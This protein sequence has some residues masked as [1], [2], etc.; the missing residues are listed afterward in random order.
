MA[1]KEKKKVERSECTGL[2]CP[3]ADGMRMGNSTLAINVVTGQTRDSGIGC[4]SCCIFGGW[5]GFYVAMWNNM[6]SLAG[7]WAYGGCACMIFNKVRV[8]IKRVWVTE[9]TLLTPWLFLKVRQGW[10]SIWREP[11]RSQSI[12]SFVPPVSIFYNLYK[13]KKYS[14]TNKW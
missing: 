14:R 13:I 3:P 7:N 2:T 11:W 4:F 12:V 8:S 5:V 9:N 6:R 10:A 1:I